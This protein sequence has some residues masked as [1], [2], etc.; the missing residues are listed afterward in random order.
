MADLLATD[1]K[2]LVADN[3]R[4]YAISKWVEANSVEN[5]YPYKPIVNP[6]AMPV[7]PPKVP[8]EGQRSRDRLDLVRLQSRLDRGETHARWA[9][10]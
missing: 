9:T 8:D 4:F 6:F 3:Y 7:F 2:H 1:N 5:T 10:T